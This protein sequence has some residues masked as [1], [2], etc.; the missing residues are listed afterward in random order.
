MSHSNALSNCCVRIETSRVVTLIKELDWLMSFIHGDQ[1]SAKFEIFETF[2]RD[3]EFTK[4]R[5]WI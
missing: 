3:E 4:A 2:E 5:P 1:Q